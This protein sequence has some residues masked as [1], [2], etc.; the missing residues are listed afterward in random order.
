MGGVP[1]MIDADDLVDAGEVAEILGLSSR[2][3]VSVYRSRYSDFPEAVIDRGTCRLWSR[4]A[5]QTWS[6]TRAHRA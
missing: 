2:N 5:V 3:A 4:S 1:Q 6:T